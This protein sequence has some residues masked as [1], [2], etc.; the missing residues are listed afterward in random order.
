MHAL[1]SINSSRISVKSFSDGDLLCLYESDF[2]LV[3]CSKILHML[4]TM[5]IDFA[6]LT[7]DG[8]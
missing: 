1:I 2:S 8:A 5:P 3:S 7:N 4:S 6:A